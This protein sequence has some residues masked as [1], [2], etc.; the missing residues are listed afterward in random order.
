[1]SDTSVE[2]VSSVDLSAASFEDL[3]SEMIRRLGDDPTRK[4]L[5]KTPARVAKSM[6]FLTAGYSQE[7]QEVIGDALFE[8]CH[9]NLV[10]VKDI[11]VYSLCEHHLLPFRGAFTRPVVR[12]THPTVG[13][14]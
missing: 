4:G 12:G 14:G 13:A 2:A 10:L 9:R 11:E 1:M 3:V 8:E 5:L 6:A 7:P